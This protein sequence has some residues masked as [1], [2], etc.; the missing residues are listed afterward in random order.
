MNLIY[1]PLSV[2]LG[3][4]HPDIRVVFIPTVSIGHS[5][6]T[7]IHDECTLNIM[8]LTVLSFPDK[9]HVALISTLALI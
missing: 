1:S 6:Q 3:F 9:I 7:S 2:Y 4:L 8:G 5:K